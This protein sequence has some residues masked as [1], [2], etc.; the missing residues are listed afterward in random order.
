MPRTARTIETSVIAKGP[1]KLDRLI[2]LLRQADGATMPA[3]IEATAW[4]AHSIRGALA[5]ALRKKGH[6]VESA[7]ADGVRAWRIVE[8]AQ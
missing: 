2:A 1:G 5:G 8:P 3:M 7:M 4:Q 6:K